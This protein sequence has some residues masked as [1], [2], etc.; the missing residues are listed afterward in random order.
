VRG[1]FGYSEGKGG[2]VVNAKVTDEGVLIPKELLRG[3]EEVE[4][5]QEGGRIVVV[6]KAA[7]DPISRL[8]SNPVSCGAADASENLDRY[9]YAADE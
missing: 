2:S 9:L 3:A 4:I 5:R 7:D 6:P 8:G 1:H